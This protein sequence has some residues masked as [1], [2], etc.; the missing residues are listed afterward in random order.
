MM[1]M[2]L[3]MKQEASGWPSDCLSEEA[4]SRYIDEFLERETAIIHESHELFALLTN[5]SLDVNYILPIYEITLLLSYE[6]LD[7]SY[8]INENVNVCIATQARLELYSY[9]E[10]L[11]KRVLYYDTNSV[12]YISKDG[13]NQYGIPTGNF[14]GDMNDELS[15]YGA[16]SYIKEFVS[17]RPKNYVFEVVT[18]TNER[19]ITR[20]VKGIKHVRTGEL[21]GHEENGFRRY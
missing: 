5:A 10:K 20:K 3:K 1:N 9:F 17:G 19:H 13:E 6:F 18:P 14:L 15:E 11:Q 7:E 12:I 4:R 8:E 21:G 16:G 2:F